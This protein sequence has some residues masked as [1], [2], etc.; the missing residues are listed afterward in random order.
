LDAIRFLAFGVFLATGAVAVGAWA[1]RTRRISPFGKSARY[2]RRVTDPVL[3]P[4]E[5]WLL[6][7][8]ANPQNAEWWLLGGAVVAGILVITIG[9]WLLTQFRVVSG[10]SGA[11]LGGLV[12]LSIYYAGQLVSIA[13]LVR[14]FGSWF[15]ATRHTRFMRPV[16]FL[17]DWIVEPLRRIIPPLGMIDISPFVAWFVVQILTSLLL[18]L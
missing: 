13:L 10:A 11:G 6:Q 9:Q 4:V 14:V 15:G 18:G 12:K 2:I 5:R 17:T 16:Y 3:D 8:G 1:V 7:R